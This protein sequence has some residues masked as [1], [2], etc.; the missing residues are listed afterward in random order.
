MGR[1]L[2]A[3]KG[4]LQRAS[5][6][7]NTADSPKTEGEPCTTHDP[8]ARNPLP[9]QR[10]SFASNRKILPTGLRALFLPL[11]RVSPAAAQSTSAIIVTDENG[12]AVSSARISLQ[13]PSLTL[14]CLT[15]FAGRCQFPAL[16][17][18]QYQLRVEKQG[19]YELLE[20]N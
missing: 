16:P 14:H 10:R 3:G 8:T 15:D 17:A 1:I 11:A 7:S 4:I 5:E 18:S 6:F 2:G 12:V 9:N 19:F 13:S 20:P